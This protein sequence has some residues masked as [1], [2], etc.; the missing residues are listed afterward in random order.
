MGERLKSGTISDEDLRELD[1]YR[2]SFAA[3]AD[4]V[5]RIVEETT[6]RPVTARPAKSTSSIVAKLNRETVRLSQMQDIA[7]CRVLVADRESQDDAIRR[8]SSAVGADVAIFDRRAVPSH[9]Y[10]AVHIVVRRA[11]GPIEVQVRTELQHIWAEVCEGAADTFGHEIKY[12]VG[13]PTLVSALLDFSATF[14]LIERDEL[15]VSEMRRAGRSEQALIDAEAVLDSMRT[16][17]LRA[18]REALSVL[19]NE[20]QQ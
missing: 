4:E 15:A 9:G 5:R 6:A 2:Q 7:G 1:T 12:G 8:I 19:G 10:R 11:C 3:D 13:N 20:R 16:K 17:A 18:A 14:D